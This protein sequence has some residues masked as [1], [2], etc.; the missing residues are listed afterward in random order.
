MSQTKFTPGPWTKPYIDGYEKELEIIEPAVWVDYD[1]VDRDEAEANLMLVVAA[2]DLYKALEIA[3][4]ALINC[5]PMKPYS[6]D[7][8]LVEIRRAMAKARGEA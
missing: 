3:E 2:P 6:G 7:G 5:I 4:L 1:D 8:P